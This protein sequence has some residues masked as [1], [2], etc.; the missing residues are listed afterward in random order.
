MVSS[1][2][3]ELNGVLLNGRLDGVENFTVTIRRAD[4]DGK[5]SKSFSSELTFF[6][7][8][9]QILK[10]ELIDD[11][12]GFSKEVSVKIYDDCCT[13][14]VFEG[15]INGEGIDW[16]EPGCWIKANVIEKKD[17]INCIRSTLIWDDFA[18]FLGR[19]HPKIRYCIEIRPDFIHYVLIGLL[20]N[21]NIFANLL[22]LTFLPALFI[23][24]GIIYVVCNIIRI[25]CSFK[26]RFK[27]LRWTIQIGPICSPPNCNTGL[28]NPII[29]IN[30]IYDTLRDINERI[31]PCGRFHP[32]PYVRDYIKNVCQKCGL[33][34]QSSILDD[35]ASPYYN[36]VLLAGQIKKGR[37]KV[38]NDGTLIGDNKP[39]ETLE[40]L[41]NQI[42]KPTFNG[43]YRI[44]NGVLI[45]E[46]KDFFQSTINWI[47][48]ESL[49]NSGDILNDEICYNWIDKERWAYG[50]FEYQPDA[51]D[52]IGNEAKLRYNDIVDWN[53]P[54]N[55]GQAGELNVQLPLSP[56]RHR[57]DGI[58][59]S[60][61]EFFQSALGGVI[62]AVF[63][64][65]FSAYDRA[66]LQNQH[67]YFNYKLL[68][69]DP[70]SGYVKNYYSDAFCGGD[71]GAAEDERY[72]YPMWFLE[73]KA[74]N[75]Y[76]KFHF[77]D[78]P[79][80]PMATKFDFTFE[81][82][83]NCDQWDS[84]GFEKSVRLIRGGQAMNG[85]VRELEV[86]FNR[87]TIKVKGFV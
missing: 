84:F 70:Q 80:S 33:T 35:P 51:Q 45:F 29:L 58:D 13:G 69:Y 44:A 82:R 4:E 54:Y 75:L 36:L 34:F 39:V 48:T 76:S 73:G 79:R 67:T 7:D 18:G 23:L 46:R 40:T 57:Q 86:D 12:L 81:F 3:I 10:S 72:N 1:L 17:E 41:L 26:I 77:I 38:S 27:I 78:D 85:I 52:Y 22:I 15:V 50:R 31:I 19:N 49:L 53:I 20:F 65:A 8:G 59:V 64:G 55:A 66:L 21:L 43:D 87:R 11:P 30:Q 60:V 37:S 6:D 9:Y 42:L 71:P 68:I 63:A 62:N 16:C 56:A 5:L 2:K 14:S 74:N 28:T 24:F 47:D 83:F 25:I 61:F 32:S